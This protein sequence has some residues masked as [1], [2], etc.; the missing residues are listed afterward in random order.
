MIASFARMLS[1][2]IRPSDILCRWGGEEFVIAAYDLTTE[3]S[4]AM[5][6]ALRHLTESTVLTLSDGRE[7]H[8]TTSIGVA[9]FAQYE[10]GN[11]YDLIG[12]ADEQLYKAKAQGRNRVCMRLVE[13]V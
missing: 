5:A 7:I 12:L 9:V 4:E 6:E 13:D 10:G 8:F 3:Q 11:I 1:T 2:T